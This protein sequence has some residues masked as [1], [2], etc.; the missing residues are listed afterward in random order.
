MKR[1]VRVLM[2]DRNLSGDAGNDLVSNLEL[3]GREVSLKLGIVY[4]AAPAHG[5]VRD[6]LERDAA[7]DCRYLTELDSSAVQAQF[8]CLRHEGIADVR[9]NC[10]GRN[11]KIDARF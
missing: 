5:K 3:R 8:I 2:L 9:G 4:G 7:L 1:D 6:P 10:A 11:L